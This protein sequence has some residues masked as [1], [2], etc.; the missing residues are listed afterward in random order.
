KSK[1]YQAKQQMVQAAIDALTSVHDDPS[2]G[3]QQK[4]RL[5]TQIGSLEKRRDALQSAANRKENQTQLA[6]PASVIGRKP[7][8]SF[9]D[10]L[11]RGGKVE[12]QRKALESAVGALSGSN[13]GTVN[14]D[15]STFNEQALMEGVLRKALASAGISADA[16]QLYRRAHSSLLNTD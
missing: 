15:L 1:M 13:A 14:L 16:S 7:L 3:A 8:D 2:T 4:T 11:F 9:L 10:R 12:A 6:D 5:A